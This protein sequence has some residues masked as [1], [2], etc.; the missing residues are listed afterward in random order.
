MSA[1]PRGH[2][3]RG[4]QLENTFQTEYSGVA[5]HNYYYIRSAQLRGQIVLSS[6][7]AVFR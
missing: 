5:D 6:F 4:L 3:S 2:S 7:V 1:Y